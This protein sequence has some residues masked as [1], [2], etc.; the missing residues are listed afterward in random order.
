[1]LRWLQT[2]GRRL[3]LLRRLLSR[4]EGRSAER[5]TAGVWCVVANVRAVTTVGEEGQERS[6]TRHFG[7]GTKVYCFPPLWG[8]GYEKVKVV[9]RH[10][11]SHRYVTMV[12][13]ARWLTNWRV[14]LVYSPHVVAVVGGHWDG[15][16]QS[17]QLAE[18]LVASKRTP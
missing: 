6:G 7:P 12:I 3:A 15:T 14:Q 5:G 17:K 10:R 13:P 9:G 2:I 16:A 11:G 8:D 18:K 4:A 1:M